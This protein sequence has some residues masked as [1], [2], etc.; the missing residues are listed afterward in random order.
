MNA[1]KTINYLIAVAM[2]AV[3]V[4]PTLAQPQPS[5][6]AAPPTPAPAAPQPVPD[7]FVSP[8]ATMITFLRSMNVKADKAK[9]DSERDDALALAIQCLDTSKLTSANRN[10]E[11]AD[12]LLVVINRLGR[13]E[14]GDLWTRDDLTTQKDAKEQVYFP[15]PRFEPILERHPQ[16]KPEGRI[17]LT[18]QDDGRWLFSAETVAGIDALYLSV[19]DL[20]VLFGKDESELG[21][22]LWLRQYMPASLKGSTLLGLEYWQW[23]ALFALILLGL[24]LDHVVRAVVRAVAGAIIKRKGG[25]AK[26]ETMRRTVRPAGLLIAAIFWVSAVGLLGLPDLGHTIVQGAARVFAIL[27]GTLFAWRLN[28]LICESLLSRAAKT[29]NKFD[30]VLIPMIRTAVRIF[31]VIFALIYGG[32]SLNLNVMPLLASLTV[33]GVGFAFAAKDTLENFFGSATVLIDQPFGVGDWIVVGDTEGTVEEIGFRSTRVRTFY[34][35]L[36]TMPNANLVRAVVDNYG[37]RKYRR[38]KTHI[39]VQYDTTPDQLVALT[40]GIRELIRSHP[41]TRKDYFQVRVHQFSGS[42]ID[43][44]LYI[45]HEVP[46][47]STELRERERLM[48]DIMRLCEQLGVQFAFPTQTLHL[49]QHDDPSA[50]EPGDAP[51]QLTERRAQVTGIRA[52]R[53]LIE[54]Q[55]WRDNPPGPVT[56]RESSDSL[57]EDDPDSDDETFIEDRSA[58]S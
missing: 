12:R 20:P 29:Q 33:G 23:V 30:D 54:N 37:K 36:I 56:Y 47:W 58:G 26:P 52:A 57:D 19:S 11:I 32:I 45:F 3:A 16:V 24:I 9:P 1:L 27:A 55:P 50:P 18:K 39:G 40:E 14:V 51:Q 38:W 17:V 8:N 34:N 49:F 43:I 2:L 7:A 25:E 35:S 46:D 10:A 4:S 28:N 13:Y 44:L 21:V 31:V 42:S 48:L 15:H 41:Y 5:P 6:T 22:G 53:K